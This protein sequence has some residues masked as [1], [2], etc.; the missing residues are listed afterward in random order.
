MMNEK[1][2]GC[3]LQQ[4]RK[5][6]HLSQQELADLLHVSNKTISK[7]ECGHGLPDASLW[8]AIAQQ[9]HVDLSQF[10]NGELQVKQV[11]IGKMD[12]IHFYRCPTCGNVMSSTTKADVSCCG[13]TLTP[14]QANYG[15]AQH[16]LQ[17]Q[18]VEGDTYITFSHPMNKQHY[19]SFAA[20]V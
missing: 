14:L 4:L 2:M 10:I 6:Q 20:Y 19:I 3:L 12:H 8:N 13:R 9:F 11:D 1:K 7:W 5:E 16:A 17:R 18:D 15:D